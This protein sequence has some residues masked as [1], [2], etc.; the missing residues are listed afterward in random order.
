MSDVQAVRL[1]MR[2]DDL[3]AS[4]PAGSHRDGVKDQWEKCLTA[5]KTALPSQTIQTWFLPIKPVSLIDE[6]LILTLPSRF[7]QE[8]IESHYGELFKEAIAAAF[9]ETVQVKFLIVSEQEE[10]QQIAA[11][12]P[13]P[14]EDAGGEQTAMPAP[15]ACDFDHRFH[16]DNFFGGMENQFALKATQH[17]A[18]QPGTTEYNPLLIQGDIGTGKTHLLHAFGNHLH[19]HR[20]ETRQILLSGEGFLHEYVNALQSNRTNQFIAQMTA[21]N[22]FYLDDIH[23]LANKTKSQEGLL[24]VISELL[25][26]K[27]QIVI[28]SQLAP[29]QLIQFNPKLIAFL[30]KGLVVNLASCDYN[31]REQIIRHHLEKNGLRLEEKI[32]FYLAEHLQNNVHQLH[33]VMVR[34][35]AQMSLL[36]K[37]MTLEEVRYIISRICPQDGAGTPGV[38]PHQEIRIDSIVT[39]T[40]NFFN[41]PVDILQGVSRKQKLINARQIAI[42]LCRELTSESLSA[43]GYHFSNLNHASVLYSYNKVKQNMTQNPRLKS[44]VD[45]I[46]SL[47]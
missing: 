45:K 34:L 31:T 4:R 8:W 41:I 10:Q 28:T 5:L 26:R 47:L 15:E 18:R 22:V 35:V 44:T 9:G 46:K 32:I 6:T 23:F 3:D 29:N 24:F 42:Y 20:T 17:V 2:S 27:A 16:F 37:S 25:K 43:I 30:Q 38:S 1:N 14:E 21:A 7:F 36:G 19:E 12:A 40:S 39:A 11:A 13:S 33:S